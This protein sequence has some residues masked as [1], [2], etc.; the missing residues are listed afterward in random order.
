[1]G[2]MDNHPTERQRLITDFHQAGYANL[3]WAISNAPE[4]DPDLDMSSTFANT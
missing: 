4:F 1:M 2:N 3:A